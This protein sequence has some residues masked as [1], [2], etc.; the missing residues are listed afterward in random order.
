MKLAKYLEAKGISQSEFAQQIE[1]Y[2]STVHRLLKGAKPDVFTL[3]RIILAT[4]GQVK[5]TDF[6][7]RAA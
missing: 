4:N 3:A 1:R 6:V 7:G 2:P 5:L